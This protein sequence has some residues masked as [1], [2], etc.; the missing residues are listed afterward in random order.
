MS[1][2]PARRLALLTF[3]LPCVAAH[4]GGFFDPLGFRLQEGHYYVHEDAG[5]AD[6]VPAPRIAQLL[7]RA[8]VAQIQ[9]FFLNSTHFDWTSHEIRYGEEIS[10]LT[11]GKHFVVNTGEGGQGPLI[12]VDRAR[13]GNEVLCN[14]PGRGLGPRPTTHTGYRNVDAFAWTSN[15][16]QSTGLC[17]AGAPPTGEF[18]PAYGVM[19]VQNAD[20]QVR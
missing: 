10:R 8:G 2:A 5:A 3:A 1:F 19:L 13:D 16:G 4:A 7:R 17:G 6:A 11:G 12:P 20:F 14:P 15:P 9:G 18:W